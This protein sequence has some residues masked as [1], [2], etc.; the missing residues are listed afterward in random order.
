MYMY[1]YICISVYVCIERQ[2]KLDDV[3]DECG[4]LFNIHFKLLMCR[5]AEATK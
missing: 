2:N 4:R 5:C 1:M 3:F